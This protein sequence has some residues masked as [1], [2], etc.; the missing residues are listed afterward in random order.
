VICYYSPLPNFDQTMMGSTRIK[1]CGITRDEDVDAAVAAGAD[2]IGLVFYP[3]SPRAVSIEQARRLAA[4][5][6]PFVTVVGLFVDATSEEVDAVLDCVPLGLLQFHGEEPPEF[7]SQFCRPWIKALRMHPDISLKESC[8]RYADAQGVLLDAWKEG[9]PG[10]TGDTFDWTRVTQDLPLPVILA[11]GLN[12]DN[13]A[14]AIAQVRPAAVDV[15]G[16]VESAPGIKDAGRIQEFIT[17]A[18]A[19]SLDGLNES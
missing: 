3:Q 15:S 7:C 6:P 2:A 11:G 16:G 5:I 10:G 12:S 13:V 14:G 1:I 8:E 19:V 18:R 17:A 4:R 9:V